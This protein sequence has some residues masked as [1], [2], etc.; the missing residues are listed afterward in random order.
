MAQARNILV[1]AETSKGS[2][3][4]VA[5]ELLGLARR[6]AAQT[7]GSVSAAVLSAC[8]ANAPKA[9]IA[10]GADRVL[11][12]PQPEPDGYY[13]SDVWL[14]AMQPVLDAA[15]AAV[16]LVGH[17]PVG[18]D[19]APRLAF[20]SKVAIATACEHVA[21]EAEKLRVT[22]P[23]YGNKAREVLTLNTTPAIITVRAKVCEALAADESRRGEIVEIAAPA[24]R[25][26][27]T[28]ERS[29]SRVPAS[30]TRRAKSSRSTR[31]PRS[32]P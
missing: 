24:S 27:S 9:L 12:V 6:L 28:A 19:L 26:R 25:S 22:R 13:E 30:A 14:N 16:I 5:F 20:R 11:V 15:Q 21:F 29:A 32:S 23:C 31:C 2:P 7:G 3:I 17:T 4:P 18:A 10:G 8:A 1:I